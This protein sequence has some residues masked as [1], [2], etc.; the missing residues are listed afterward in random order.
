[1]PANAL[2]TAASAAAASP[3]TSTSASLVVVVVA[4]AAAAVVVVVAVVVVFFDFESSPAAVACNGAP[5]ANNA[6]ERF[7]R[8]DNAPDN[9]RHPTPTINFSIKFQ[10]QSKN[11][12]TLHL[13]ALALS[14]ARKRCGVESPRNVISKRH[15][16]RLTANQFEQQFKKAT[17]YTR[18][19]YDQG[20][21]F[22]LNVKALKLV[23]NQNNSMVVLHHYRKT[24]LLHNNFWFC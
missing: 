5:L 11:P 20:F 1:L 3:P 17:L 14:A 23:S 9:S 24:T 19:Q 6:S 10:K 22:T 12:N 18:K 8:R 13:S 7:E 2:R 21:F 15:A 4:A 16:S